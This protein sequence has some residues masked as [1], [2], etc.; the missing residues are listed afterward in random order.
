M[1]DAAFVS[2]GGAGAPEGRRREVVVSGKRVKTVDVHA[3]C[4]VPAAMALMGRKLET[5]A[6]LMT[7]TRG[8]LQRD[9]RP[10]HRRRGAQHQ[11]LLVRGRSGRRDGADPDPER[12]A[13]RDLRRPAR[14]LRRVRERGAPASGPGGR[15]ARAGRQALRPARRRARRERRGPRAERPEVS[16]VLG[17]GR[18]AR[19]PGLHPPA[20]H[21][22]AGADGPA[23]GQRA[24]HQH[25]RQPA[26]DH[27]RALAPHLR[28]HPRP[29]PRPQDLRRPRRRL[30]PLLRRP[31]RTRCRRRSPIA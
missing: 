12:D 22:R 10:G 16:P 1:A 6:L 28:G 20:G 26:R 3:H 7:D 31:L 23:R 24:A 25:H 30:S 27:D 13:G 17:Q 2:C 4:A 18:A 15:A 11:S 14:P 21:G 8:R 9:G 5:E 19:R 29:I